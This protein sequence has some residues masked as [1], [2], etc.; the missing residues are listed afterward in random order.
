M[1]KPFADRVIIKPIQTQQDTGGIIIPDT[2][3]EKPNKGIVVSVGPGRYAELTGVLIPMASKEGQE[4]FFGKH[5]TTPIN[6]DG[7]DYLI[8]KESEILL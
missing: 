5:S 8:I 7:E 6:I 1:I 2:A 4:V 3:K